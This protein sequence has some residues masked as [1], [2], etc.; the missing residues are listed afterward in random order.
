MERFRAISYDQLVWTAQIYVN[1]YKSYY[2]IQSSPAFRT[3]EAA[4][5]WAYEWAG[6][7]CKE[8]I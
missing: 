3:P 7:I 4:I 5:R 8:G 2:D 1:C 6:E